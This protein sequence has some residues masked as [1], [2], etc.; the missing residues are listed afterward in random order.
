MPEIPAAEYA[1]RLRRCGEAMTREELDC[2]LVLP[3]SNFTYLTGRRFARER[4]R[5]LVAL[6][7]IGRAHV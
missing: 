3:G 2:L 5:L 7:K 6:V 1:E 4:H